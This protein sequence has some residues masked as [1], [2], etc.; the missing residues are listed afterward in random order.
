[1]ITQTIRAINVT[2]GRMR[3]RGLRRISSTLLRRV[4]SSQEML[5]GQF[6]VPAMVRFGHQEGRLVRGLSRT[7]IQ[8]ELSGVVNRYLTMA[9]EGD[10]E[11][12]VRPF[13]CDIYNL[14]SNSDSAGSPKLVKTRSKAETYFSL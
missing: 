13:E 6:L 7:R 8:V 2:I 10:I 5:E 1:V 3:L 11:E 9:D 4:K 12:L 14:S